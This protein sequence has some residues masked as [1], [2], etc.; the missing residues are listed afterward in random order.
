MGSF[1]QKQAGKYQKYIDAS[2]SSGHLREAVKLPTGEDINEWLAVHTV[3]FY[4]Q[5]HMLYLTVTDFCTPD[6]CPMITAGPKYRYLWADGVTIKQ[7]FEVSAPKYADFLF[8][9]I[10]VQL[11]DE[12]IFPQKSGA[13]FPP[14]FKGVIKTILKRLFRVY[15]HIYHSHFEKVLSLTVE[16]HLYTCFKHF[17]LFTSEFRLIDKSELAPLHDL[18]E[19]TLQP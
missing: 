1:L 19:A 15:A 7:P 6:T 5:V 18:V 4:N 10:E 12:S 9:W 17:V 8:H 14:K 16:D 2:L 13:P 11:D 3:D